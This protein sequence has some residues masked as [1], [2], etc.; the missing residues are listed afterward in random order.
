MFISFE[1]IK[2]ERTSVA[3][4]KSANTSGL[5]TLSIFDVYLI[6]NQLPLKFLVVNI[7]SIEVLMLLNFL[8]SMCCIS[9]E[10]IV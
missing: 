4:L 5:A 10:V 1:C 9:S 7:A 8:T 3:S 6:V 2:H